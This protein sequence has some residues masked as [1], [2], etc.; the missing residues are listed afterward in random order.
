MWLCL[1]PARQSA[2]RG[3]TISQARRDAR[4]G[5][6]GMGNVRTEEGGSRRDEGLIC[7]H[8]FIG[9]CAASSAWRRDLR[10]RA[11]TIKFLA[12]RKIYGWYRPAGGNLRDRL[13]Y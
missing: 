6:K 13:V 7:L 3:R 11:W 2:D 12:G 9:F 5:C 8:P 1:E 10:A 4:N